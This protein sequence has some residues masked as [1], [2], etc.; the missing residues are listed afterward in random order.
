M[1]GATSQRTVTSA[2]VQG[3]YIPGEMGQIAPVR[4][5]ES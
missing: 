2:E 4:A 3:A 5:Q 1:S